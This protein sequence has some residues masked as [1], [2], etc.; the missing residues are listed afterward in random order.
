MNICVFSSSSNAI[1]D[2]YV[3]DAIDLAFDWPGK[4]LFDKRWLKCR[5]DGCSDP[6]GWYLRS[7]NHWYYS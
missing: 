3:N 7:K 6:R 2:V 4:V 5:V 1:P